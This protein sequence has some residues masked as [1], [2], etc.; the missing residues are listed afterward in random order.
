LRSSSAQRLQV[1][2]RG[3]ED[4]EEKKP[5][6]KKKGGTAYDSASTEQKGETPAFY[7]QEGGGKRKKTSLLKK[8][9]CLW[10]TIRR[11]AWHAER[12]KRKEKGGQLRLLRA[13]AFTSPSDD[14]LSEGGGKEKKKEG[15]KRRGKGDLR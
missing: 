15:E 10:L 5:R 14:P 12:K 7:S 13:F 2:V 1:C 9:S 6:K 3:G 11:N 8:R 4:F